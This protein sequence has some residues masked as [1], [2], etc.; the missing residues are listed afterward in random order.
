MTR[1]QR[2]KFYANRRDSSGVINVWKSTN[3]VADRPPVLT[4]VFA[5]ASSF[6]CSILF[7][8]KKFHFFELNIFEVIYTGKR[9]IQKFEK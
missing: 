7:W 5:G 2:T 3:R 9:N 8:K 6:E 4:P 1:S